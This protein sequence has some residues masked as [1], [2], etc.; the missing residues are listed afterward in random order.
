[1]EHSIPQRKIR[2]DRKAQGMLKPRGIVGK[3]NRAS[4]M[5]ESADLKLACEEVGV[6][7]DLKAIAHGDFRR[8]CGSSCLSVGWRAV[9]VE[10]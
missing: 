4:I 8:C 2:I 9:G 5:G 3:A 6:H 1:M 7:P 10:A